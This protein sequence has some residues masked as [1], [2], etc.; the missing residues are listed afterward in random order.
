MKIL[1]FN[2]Y[3]W[4]ENFYINQVAVGLQSF[5]HDV[6]VLTGQPNYP[7]GKVYRNYSAFSVSKETWNGI[8]INRFP[9]VPRGK[10]SATRLIL[11]YLSYI[12][13]G[14]IFSSILMRRKKFDLIFVYAP[15]PIFQVIPSIFL[16]W[17]KKIPVVLWVQDLWPESAIATG[18]MKSGFLARVVNLLV[19]FCYSR[20]D[21]I[22]VQS[23]AFIQP[24]CTLA[25]N[26]KVI[27]YPNSVEKAFYSPDNLVLPDIPSLNNAFSV[28]FA[29]NVGVAQSMETIVSAAEKLSIYEEINIVILGAGSKIDW[30]YEE[31]KKRKL[32]NVFVEGN[33]P[34][35]I[36]PLLLRKASALLVSLTDQSIFGLTVPN[37]IQ[38][39]LA[40]GRP[41]VASLNGEG[42]RLVEEAGAGFTAPA[43]NPEKL[44]EVILKLYFMTDDERDKLGRSGQDFFRKNFDQDQLL[45]D[46]IDHFNDVIGRVEL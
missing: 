42:S 2:Q 9:I 18:Y 15:S 19:R 17:V 38:A 11:N 35:E 14:L 12:I 31:I 16:G 26:K 37:K 22:L 33:Y 23:K 27:Y 41:I 32:K 30:V 4:P 10:K 21:L 28:V 43:E 45:K 36:M 1:I 24:V 40:V 3:F 44:A 13:S 5:G 7:D 25:P 20:V 8:K 29:G 39:Y 6:E 46:L 34:R